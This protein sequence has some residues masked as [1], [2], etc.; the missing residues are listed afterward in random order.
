MSHV[1]LPC[2]NCVCLSSCK[3]KMM[4]GGVGERN[5]GIHTNFNPTVYDEIL[6]K[7][8]IISEYIEALEVFQEEYEIYRQE[9]KNEELSAKRQYEF[10]AFMVRSD[11]GQ[12]PM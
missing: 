4:A 10:I 1:T 9:V 5:K 2:I 3:S 8:V 12:T 11:N 6:K 7:C